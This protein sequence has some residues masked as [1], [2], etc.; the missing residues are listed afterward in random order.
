MEQSTSM[1]QKKQELRM[2]FPK[3]AR[4]QVSIS[5]HEAKKLSYLAIPDSTLYIA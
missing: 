3:L 2:K 4:E 1:S 5:L